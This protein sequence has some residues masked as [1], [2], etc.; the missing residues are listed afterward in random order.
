MGQRELEFAVDQLLDVGTTHLGGLDFSNPDDVDAG[1]PGTVS[2]SH[3]LITRGDGIGSAHLSVLLVHVMGPGSAVV[4]QPDAKVLDL[5]GML[6]LHLADGHDL[7]VGMFDLLE[8]AK[9]VKVTGLGDDLVGSKDAHAVE[10]GIGIMLGW[11]SATDDLILTDGHDGGNG[12]SGIDVG[13]DG[14]VV[15]GMGWTRTFSLSNP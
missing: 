4:S 15:D 6:L 10:L 3:V 2:C 13:M 14:R 7:S 12:G 11:N 9:E 5:Q 1:E 8:L